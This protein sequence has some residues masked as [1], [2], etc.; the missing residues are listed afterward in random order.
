MRAPTLVPGT[1]TTTH[2]VLNDFG[3]L[4]CAY[5]ETDE[6]KADEW[7]IVRNI[8]NG[9]YS[10]PVRVVAFNVAEGWSRDVNPRDRRGCFRIRPPRKLF[11]SA[12]ARLCRAHPRHCFVPNE[13][14]NH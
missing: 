6:A 7:T 10:N 11:Q 1:G 8:G 9:A 4:G 3:A 5:L 12:S 13:M 2:L 14:I